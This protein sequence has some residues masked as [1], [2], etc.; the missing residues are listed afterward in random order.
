MIR[1]HWDKHEDRSKVNPMPLS[2]IVIGSK[3]DVFANQF[4]SVKRKQV[5]L[6]MR[7]ISHAHGCDLVF[8]SVKEKLP[9]SLFKG[10][11]AYRS[12]PQD[13]QQTKVERDHNQAL[14]VYAG[15]D[16]FAQI[17]EPEGAGMRRNVAF[18][19]LW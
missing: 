3:F 14:N 10:M 13:S 2:V 15:S 5:C 1:A 4:E 16:A 19:K 11:L 18:E 9:A 17:G 8:A 12:T 6:A 7:Y